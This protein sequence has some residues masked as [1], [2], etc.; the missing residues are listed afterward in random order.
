MIFLVSSD[1]AATTLSLADHPLLLHEQSKLVAINHFSFQ[2]VVH[3]IWNFS[4]ATLEFSQFEYGI[5]YADI[6]K[7]F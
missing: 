6:C 5:F 4:N 7:F 2:Q 3:A 1:T